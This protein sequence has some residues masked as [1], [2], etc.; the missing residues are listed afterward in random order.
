MLSAMSKRC[1]HIEMPKRSGTLKKSL[2]LDLVT[3]VTPSH[4]LFTKGATHLWIFLNM[5]LDFRPVKQ[6]TSSYLPNTSSTY[7]FVCRLKIS[8]LSFLFY[9]RVDC[10]LKLACLNVQLNKQSSALPLLALTSDMQLAEEYPWEGQD[11]SGAPQGY[12][13]CS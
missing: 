13:H 1:T 12:H 2:T 11:R 6:L 10:S 3:L 4:R 9:W 5:D 7:F 8:F